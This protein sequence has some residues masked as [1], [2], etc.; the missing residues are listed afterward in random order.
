MKAWQYIPFGHTV[1][2][3]PQAHVSFA[4]SSV[5]HGD[6]AFGLAICP[7]ASAQPTDMESASTATAKILSMVIPSLD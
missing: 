4:C 6:R 3:G 7:F 5:E 2:A 1:F